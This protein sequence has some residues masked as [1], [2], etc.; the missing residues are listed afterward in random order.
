MDRIY[1]LARSVRISI[2]DGPMGSGSG[3]SSLF[4]WLRHGNISETTTSVALPHSRCLL[5]HRYFKRAWT[6]QEVALAR[7][8]Y[9]H[10]NGEEIFLGKE[11]L[12]KLQYIATRNNC[13]LLGGLRLRRKANSILTGDIVSCLRAGIEAECADPRDKIFAVLS[14]MDPKARSL[15]PVDYALD[16]ET[17]WENAALAVIISN[18][19][20]DAISYSRVRHMDEPNPDPN[21]CSIPTLSSVQ[22]KDFLDKASQESSM[23]GGIVDFILCKSEIAPLSQLQFKNMNRWREKIEVRIVDDISIIPDLPDEDTCQPVIACRGSHSPTNILPHLQVRA[24]FIDIVR[25]SRCVRSIRREYRNSNSIF[26]AR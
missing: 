8:V 9:L 12:E 17:V 22:F 6:I 25:S 21:L 19:N 7:T 16:L 1:F 18:R 26:L 24:H 11:T 2:Q 10:V 3:Y 5:W 15:I 20:L 23:D 14:L 4:D 13:R